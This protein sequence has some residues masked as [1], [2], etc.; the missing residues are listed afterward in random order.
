MTK[1]VQWWCIRRKKSEKG[2]EKY[3]EREKE[4][5]GTQTHTTT[6]EGEPGNSRAISL[7]THK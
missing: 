4:G 5:K 1:R 6:P 3:K 7:K 2:K